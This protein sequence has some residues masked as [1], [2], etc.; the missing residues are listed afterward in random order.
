MKTFDFKKLSKEQEEELNK[1][2]AD[3]ID[4]ITTNTNG[5]SVSPDRVSIST[6]KGN[7]SLT[8]MKREIETITPIGIDH[9]RMYFGTLE[10]IVRAKKRKTFWS[11]FEF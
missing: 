6:S 5:I 1:L 7:M 2:L 10:T 4:S 3:M 11:R 8:E 9:L